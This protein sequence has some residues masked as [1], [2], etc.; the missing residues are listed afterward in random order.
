MKNKILV[1]KGYIDKIR[2]SDCT[3]DLLT[4]IQYLSGIASTR[5]NASELLGS[6][7]KNTTIVLHDYKVL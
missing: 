5:V 1:R 4:D 7:Y 2:I 3:F 6:E